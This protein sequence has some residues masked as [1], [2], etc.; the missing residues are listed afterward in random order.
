MVQQNQSH[1]CQRKEKRKIVQSQDSSRSYIQAIY[2]VLNTS[3]A[4]FWRNEVGRASMTLLSVTTISC[5]LLTV[6]SAH[7]WQHTAWLASTPVPENR[8][9][10]ILPTTCTFSLSVSEVSNPITIYIQLF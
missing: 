7:Q 3:A 9:S 5:C 1:S 8:R 2:R 4:L 10:S 6:Q